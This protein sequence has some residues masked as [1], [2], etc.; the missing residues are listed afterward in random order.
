MEE[1][2]EDWP[3]QI[4]RST[5]KRIGLAA[6]G[7]VAVISRML[8]QVLDLQP[9]DPRMSLRA[10]PVVIS[11]PALYGLLQ[12]D[13]ADAAEYLGLSILS[14]NHVYQPRNIV[15]AYAGHG[16]GLCDTYGD[17]ETCRRE[18]IGLPVHE[19]LLV[20]HTEHALFLHVKGMREAYE[21]ASRDIS[22]FADFSLG[23][24]EVP[25][26]AD[27]IGQA[28]R[29]FLQEK[30]RR[31]GLPVKFTT[32]MTGS[33][34][35][36]EVTEAIEKAIKDL[37]CEVEMLN[38]EPEYIAARGAAELAWRSLERAVPVKEL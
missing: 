22:I 12:E 4:L 25:G 32:I 7:D 26:L 29:Q 31:V 24:M 23:H 5:R 11:Y 33:K 20:E 16:L 36:K 18:G 8:R 15:A 2:W 1:L 3:R 38:A 37:G 21:L 10:N 28:V 30:Y 27:K 14:G 34:I 6:S 35:R 9:A 19:V 17:R 13:I